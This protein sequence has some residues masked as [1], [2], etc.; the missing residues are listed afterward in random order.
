MEND[1]AFKITAPQQQSGDLAIDFEPG[2]GM[3]ASP[4]LFI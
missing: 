4:W 1:A 2:P 3:E